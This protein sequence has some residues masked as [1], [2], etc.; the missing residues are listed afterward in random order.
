MI[1]F[2][3]N[4]VSI[5]QADYKEVINFFTQQSSKIL[6]SLFVVF[7]YFFSALTIS[8]IFEDYINDEKIKNVANKLLNIFAILI[9]LL[10]IIGIYNLS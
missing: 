3:I 2:I 9:P 7:A 8:E 10:T 6:F 5:Y 1:W 4:L